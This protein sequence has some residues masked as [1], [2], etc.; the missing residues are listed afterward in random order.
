MGVKVNSFIELWCLICGGTTKVV[1]SKL[2]LEH[3]LQQINKKRAHH[4]PSLCQFAALKHRCNHSVGALGAQSAALTQPSP[5]NIPGCQPDMSY[6]PIRMIQIKS[7][8]GKDGVRW[9]RKEI[10]FGGRV[11]S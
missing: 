10:S 11:R 4:K 5:T 9:E 2:I 7:E 6:A 8:E 1:V 3:F